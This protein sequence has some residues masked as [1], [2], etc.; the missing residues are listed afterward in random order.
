AVNPLV[1]TPHKYLATAAEAAG[2]RSAAIAAHRTLLTL[3]PLDKAGHHY[4]L[5]K[6][7]AEEPGQLP[8]ARRQVVRA[9]EEAPRYREAHRLLLEIVDKSGGPG[10]GPATR[11]ATQPAR[12]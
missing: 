7:L 5:A 8:E 4:R 2:D 11:P 12:D 6:Q 3:D 9:L 1:P 10:A